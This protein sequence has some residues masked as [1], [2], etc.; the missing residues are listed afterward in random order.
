[1][2]TNKSKRYALYAVAIT[3]VA[4]LTCCTGGR[5]GRNS[6]GG[7][8]TVQSKPDLAMLPDS[9][10]ASVDDLQWEVEVLDTVTPGRL[11][12][13]RNGYDTVPGV[14]AFRGGPRRDAQVYAGTVKGTPSTIQRDWSFT[15]GADNTKTSVGSFGGGT[16]WTGQPLYVKW[17]DA[18]LAQQR[19]SPG[20]TAKLSHEEIMV[21]SLC[22]KV[23]FL[24]FASGTPSREA[25]DVGNPIKGTISLDPA[26]NGS[27]YVGQGV[28]A[29]PPI[30]HLAIDLSTHQ[31]KFFY[32]PDNKAWRHWGAYD[33]NPVVVGQ[34]LFWPGENGT[35]YKYSRGG[36][37]ELTIH[38][39][40][41]YKAKGDGGAGVE[42]SMSVFKNYG[43]FGDNHGDIVCVDL[44]T[45]HPI[46]H[47]DNH[48]DIDGT[49]VLEIVDG[50]PWLYSACE[51]DQQGD[52]GICHFV[53]LNG[54]TGEKVWE[55]EL[56]CKKLHLGGKHFD[57]GLY[58][59]PLLGGGDC[60]DMLFASICQ[61][62]TS[63][64]ADFIAFS[65]KSGEIV[66]RVPMKY[67][68]WSSPVAFYNEKKQLFIVVGDSAGHL[69][70][71]EGKTGKLLFCETLGH[72]FESSPVVVGSSF[73]VGS[74]GEQIHK[75]TVH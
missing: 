22:G 28:P 43:Y 56:P 35:L 9:A 59:T 67:F 72:N 32:G 10:F 75:F 44:N 70:L 11:S 54:L 62:G 66:W 19:K 49:P 1:M 4:C 55:Q 71:F 47:Y 29:H 39:K 61:P 50:K 52:T 7:D 42:C 24:D 63:G 13:L 16:G 34:F 65:K 25:V 30:G 37:G 3:A 31:R 33:S 8:S 18:Q 51:V 5:S 53:K 2:T 36:N 38:S 26:L 23:Y 73:V 14:F 27:L 57:G 12:D 64:N 46:W 58:C 15:T 68:A 74:R 45:L 20:A 60:A 6:G 21:G 69:Y 48:D 17:S 40:L 41:R